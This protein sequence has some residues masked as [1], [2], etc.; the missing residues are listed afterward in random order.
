MK[1]IRIY[2]KSAHRDYLIMQRRDVIY[3]LTSSE[4]HEKQV[5]LRYQEV[6]LPFL[7]AAV[8]FAKRLPG[9]TPLPMPDQIE[10]VKQNGFMVVQLMVSTF[11]L[12]TIP[13]YGVGSVIC[14]CLVF[15]VLLPLF[16]Y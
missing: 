15:T 14:R 12:T 8:K 5:F 6:M 16:F 3:S 13:S 7:E 9:F 1:N 10:L 11:V 4:F 2:E